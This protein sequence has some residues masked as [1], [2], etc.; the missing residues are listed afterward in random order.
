M[1]RVGVFPCMLSLAPT[2]P[3]AWCHIYSA[4]TP[5]CGANCNQGLKPAQTFPTHL[6][7]G[8]AAILQVSAAAHWVFLGRIHSCL[9]PAVIGM[10]FMMLNA[11]DIIWLGKRMY[12]ATTARNAKQSFRPATSPRIP[13]KQRL[14]GDRWKPG[15]SLMN[16]RPTDFQKLQISWA[17]FKRQG[18]SWTPFGARGS[19]NRHKTA[20]LG[21]RAARADT[22]GY[23]SL[24]GN[25]LRK[26][27]LLLRFKADLRPLGF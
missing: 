26:F 18:E 15:K 13:H 27:D 23:S 6:G 2:F 5:P 8:P 3:K 7:K 11:S 20:R 19:V 9:L 24:L 4:T 22:F 16:R 1:G 17:K 14:H 25:R 10:C 21:T 12:R